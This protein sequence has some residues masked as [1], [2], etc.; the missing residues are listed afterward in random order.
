MDVTLLSKKLTEKSRGTYLRKNNLFDSFGNFFSSVDNIKTNRSMTI[1]ALKTISSHLDGKINKQLDTLVARYE[2]EKTEIDFKEV[3]KVLKNV[4][5]RYSIRFA[6]IVYSKNASISGNLWGHCQF[7]ALNTLEMSN[8]VEVKPLASTSVTYKSA[9]EEEFKKFTASWEI[10]NEF[11]VET[12]GYKKISSSKSP[13]VVKIDR[14][15]AKE[16]KTIYQHRLETS[17]SEQ[18]EKIELLYDPD[19]TVSDENLAMLAETIVE[20]EKETGKR[21]FVSITEKDEEEF[22]VISEKMESAFVDYIAEHGKARS[23]APRK[24]IKR[25][26]SEF[27]QSSAQCETEPLNHLNNSRW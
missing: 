20:K 3:R 9:R 24:D 21:F 4:L 14:L 10:K 17:V 13:E 25:L 2:S 7:R 5:P 6:P 12:Y 26:Q 15:T 16:F 18:T 22:K 23:L 1:Q 8:F 19:G 11:N 27:S